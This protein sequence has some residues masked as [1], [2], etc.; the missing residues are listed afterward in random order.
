LY[1]GSAVSYSPD[2]NVIEEGQWYEGKMDG[3][4]KLYDPNGD[5]LFV[6]VWNKGQFV[7]RKERQDDRWVEKTFEQLDPIF[8]EEIRLTMESPPCG[9]LPGQPEQE[10]TSIEAPELPLEQ[11]PH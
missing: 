11:S 10:T 3:Q 6:M 1:H 4:W 9:P 8:Q 2:G 5:L 7:L